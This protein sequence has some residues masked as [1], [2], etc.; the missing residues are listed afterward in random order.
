[1]VWSQGRKHFN[2]A[3]YLVLGLDRERRRATE[4][5]ADVATIEEEEAKAEATTEE[6]ADVATMEEADEANDGGFL[7]QKGEGD[8]IKDEDVVK[9]ELNLQE[10]RKRV[11]RAKL[12]DDKVK[13]A[14]PVP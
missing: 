7:A 12:T 5:G 10:L 9:K 14:Q 1:M 11:R 2:S 3:N 13:M 6:E 8:E 4:E